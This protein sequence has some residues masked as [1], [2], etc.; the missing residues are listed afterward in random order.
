MKTRKSIRRIALIVIGI[1]LST[2][3]HAQHSTTFKFTDTAP[4]KVRQV[5]Q[6]NAD[7]LFDEINRKYDQDK[8]ELDL[9]SSVVT[10]FARDRIT[11]MWAVSHFYC[12]RTK[13]I[14]HV[15]ERVSANVYQVREI[16]VRFQE[17]EGDTKWIVLEFDKSGKISDIYCA[18]SEHEYTDFYENGN[19]VTNMRHREMIQSFVSDF[20]TAYNMGKEGLDLIE[21]M[22]SED[23][24]IITGKVVNYKTGIK[25]DLSRT[26]TNNKMIVYSVQNKKEYMTKLRG[27]FSRNEYINIRFDS[28]EIFQSERN[29][30]IYGVRLNQYWHVSRKANVDGYYDEGKLFLIID[31]RNESQPEVWVRTWQPFEDQEFFGMGDFNF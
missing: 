14:Q 16:P 12:T 7:V 1:L 19:E 11:T 10:P 30:N 13:V 23:A 21:K 17:G 20:F 5:M 25:N 6:N 27:I 24:L 31:F 2:Q 4:A 26:L 29:P 8:S 15:D 28:V 22:Y 9:P 3:V 18:L